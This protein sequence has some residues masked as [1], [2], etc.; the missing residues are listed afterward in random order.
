[1][2]GRSKAASCPVVDRADLIDGI[3]AALR[4][5]HDPEIP[6]NIHDLGLIYDVDVDDGGGVS[7][8]MTLTAPGCPVADVL[9][10]DVRRE[11]GSV[12]GVTSVRVE[13]V[14]D[15]PWTVDR[16]SDEAALELGLV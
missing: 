2:S 5:I 13:L 4:T 15:P 11:V 14:W 9:V 8:V 1:M 6:A 16:M 10:E 3:V 7:I 12:A